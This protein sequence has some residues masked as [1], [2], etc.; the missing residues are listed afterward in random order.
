MATRKTVKSALVIIPPTELWGEIQKIRSVH[1]KAY[2]RWA[3]HINLMYPFL[4]EEDISKYIPALTEELSTISPFKVTFGKGS[5]GSFDHSKSSTVW[6][7]PSQVHKFVDLEKRLVKIIPQCND[8]LEYSEDGYIPHLSLA[9]TNKSYAERF[10]NKLAATWEPCSFVVD[11]LYVLTRD[12]EDPFTISWVLPLGR[13]GSK[14]LVRNTDRSISIEAFLSSNT[15]AD[16]DDDEDEDEGKS[17]EDS[18]SSD[19]DSDKK[20]EKVKIKKKVDTIDK[21]LKSKK[22]PKLR[23]SNDV[24]D[25]II[26]DKDLNPEDFTITYKDRFDGMM[27]V[28]FLEFPTEDVPFHRIWLFKKNGQVVWD[29]A[30][31]IDQVFKSTSK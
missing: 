15:S 17:K 6:L 8:L 26:W 18:S 22:K 14:R 20:S 19:S 7:G 31:R 12:G 3:P 29:R 2:K 13:D 5:F 11:A 25:R 23:T 21:E 24:F 16:D 1:D 30:N 4:Y 27:E 10:K 28:P 9:Q